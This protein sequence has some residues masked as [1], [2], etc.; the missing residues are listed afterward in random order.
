MGTTRQY[1]V[2]S[3]G[4]ICRQTRNSASP[5]T[6][7][8]KAQSESTHIFCRVRE[9]LHADR[10]IDRV[11]PSEGVDIVVISG[12]SHGTTVSTEDKGD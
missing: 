9:R 11:S 1:A 8:R 10:S 7:K 12:E 6:K 4:S 5:L 2:C 3:F